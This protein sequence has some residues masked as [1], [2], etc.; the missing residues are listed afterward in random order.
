M[1]NY[2]Q[3]WNEL[4]GA[5][6]SKMERRMLASIMKVIQPGDPQ[7]I[8]PALLT[9]L[10]YETLSEQERSV[11]SFGP[12]M[13]AHMNHFAAGMK[14]LVQG[15]ADLRKEL[16]KLSSVTYRYSAALDQRADSFIQRL[17]K[18]ATARMDDDLKIQIIRVAAITLSFIAGVTLMMAF[19]S[20]PIAQSP[21]RETVSAFG[22][23]HHD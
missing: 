10:L 13:S 22:E 21:V 15:M 4:F 11:L 6:C 23:A 16:H 18:K 2:D 8:M 1:D 14:A 17:R 12:A 9:R 7:F 19:S 20:R 3:F 5:D